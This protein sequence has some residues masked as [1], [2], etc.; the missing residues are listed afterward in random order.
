[1]ITPAF[2]KFW[3]STN[4][5]QD[6]FTLSAPADPPVADKII[7]KLGE[8]CLRLSSGRQAQLHFSFI[9]QG[10]PNYAKALLDRPAL[11]PILRSFGEGGSPLII[12]EVHK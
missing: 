8:A 11:R 3:G 5:W 4:D 6:Y 12:I 7:E 2:K 9:G 10:G 1:L